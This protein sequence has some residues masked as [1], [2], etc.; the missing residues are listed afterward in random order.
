MA[1]PPLHPEWQEGDHSGLVQIPGNRSLFLRAAGPKRTT[2]ST[3]A[4]IIEHGLGGSC[5]EWLAVQRLVAKIARVYVYERAG[6]VPSDPPSPEQPPTYTTIAADLKSLLDSA[7][8]QPPYVLVGHSLGGHLI[9]QF[10][11]DYGSDVVKGMLIVDSA[12]VTTKLPDNW[13]ELLGD[14]SYFGIAGVDAN[15]AIPDDEYAEVKA[16]D[17]RNEAIASLEMQH[18]DQ[19]A[20]E[21][22]DR[23]KGKQALGDGRLSVIFCDEATDLRKIYDYGVRNGN[24]SNE[25]QEA[26]KK[27]LEDM[28]QLD[29]RGMRKHLALSS[30]ARFVK[31]VGKQKTHNVQVVDPKFVAR[32]V[33]WVCGL[34]S[35]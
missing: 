33:E 8:V 1:D 12:P 27:R 16:G 19:S 13:P 24:G 31:A 17:A 30:N 14:S 2:K 10:L 7:D 34:T 32:E 29:E 28:S 9:R 20:S 23:L 3:P 18:K 11:A 35:G 15:H 26:L 21:L 6:Y 5:S 4:V 25:A 22:N